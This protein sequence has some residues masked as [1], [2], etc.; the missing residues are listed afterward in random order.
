MAGGERGVERAAELLRKEV[1]R[2]MQ[3]LGVRRVADLGP[4]QV[5]F[6]DR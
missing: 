1:V 3:L 2:T 5:G 4:E 6:R